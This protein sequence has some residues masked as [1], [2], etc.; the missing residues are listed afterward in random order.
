M[1]EETFRAGKENGSLIEYDSLGKIITKGEFVDGKEEGNWLIEVGDHQEIGNYEY[2]LRQ[3]EWEHY[4]IS[5]GALRFKGSF[6]DDLP[7]DK[8]TWYYDTGVKMLE[9]NYVSGIQDG[10]W[11]RYNPDGSVFVSIEYSSGN[12]VKVDGLKLKVKGSEDQ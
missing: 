9:G 10:E 4:Y 6:F 3:G 7:Q 8:H 2:G 11:R 1:R 12:E 5:N